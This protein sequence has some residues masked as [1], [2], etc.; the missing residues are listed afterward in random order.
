MNIEP[1]IPR[2]LLPVYFI[3]HGY[4]IGAEIGVQAGTH[5]AQILAKWDGHLILV[6]CWSHYRGEEYRDL[7]NVSQTE[8]EAYYK[9]CLETLS[10]FVGRYTI[11]RMFSHEAAPLVKDG[12]LDFVYIDANHTF[13]AV[14]QDLHCWYPKVKIG[15]LISGHDYTQDSEDPQAGN[16]GV[17]AAVNKF[18]ERKAGTL[19]VSDEDWPTWYFVKEQE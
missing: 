19:F 7:A 8:Q 6:D 4:R 1:G 18:V 11:M 5:A 16:F 17:K 12:T 15:G 9:A 3:D 10:P 14:T 13:A 2:S